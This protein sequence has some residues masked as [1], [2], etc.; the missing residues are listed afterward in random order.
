MTNPLDS[1]LVSLRRIIRVTE[2]GARDLARK[3]NMATSELLTLQIVADQP[4]ISPGALAK[5]MSLSPVT[6][7][8]ILQKLEAKG[9]I[10]KVKSPLDKRKLEVR[11]TAA[12]KDEIEGAPSSLQ[13]EFMAGFRRLPEWE[14]QMIAAVLGRV[15]SLLNADKIDASPILDVGPLA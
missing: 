2:A 12:G 15:T 13:A 9:L 6:S 7:T 11:L 3:S 14:Q 5:A 10:E 1:S 4:S 8:V